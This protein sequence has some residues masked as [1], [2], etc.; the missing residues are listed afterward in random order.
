VAERLF[1]TFKVTR[2]G[3]DGHPMDHVMLPVDLAE[4]GG[5]SS[6]SFAVVTRRIQAELRRKATRAD[7][8]AEGFRIEHCR[9]CNAPIVWAVTNGGK[10][11]PVDAEPVDDGHVELRPSTHGRGVIA[12]VLEA[13]A[14]F[15][16][17]LRK[18]HFATCPDADGW[19]SR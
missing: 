15:A 13:E 2:E 18:S 17:P 6:G 7:V 8:T 11:M 19:R 14:L 12:T 3:E 10:G 16:G 1:L 9:S 5:L 4:D